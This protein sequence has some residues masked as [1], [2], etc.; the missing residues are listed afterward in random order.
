VPEPFLGIEVSYAL[1]ATHSNAG[2]CLV[3]T[4]HKPLCCRVLDYAT[5]RG[6]ITVFARFPWPQGRVQSLGSFPA[7][8]AE[9]DSQDNPA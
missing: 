5:E 1:C 4:P 9:F 8:L 3:G 7:L 6:T 2:N